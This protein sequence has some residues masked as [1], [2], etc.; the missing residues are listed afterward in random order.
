MTMLGRTGLFHTHHIYSLGLF[1]RTLGLS[2]K[3]WLMKQA[4]SL[5]WLQVTHQSVGAK[6]KKPY[7]KVIKKL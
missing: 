1:W 4:A 7:K 5:C 6:I 2:I 3:S